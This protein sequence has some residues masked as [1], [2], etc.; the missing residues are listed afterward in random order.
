[1]SEKKVILV[2]TTT[3]NEL[4]LK[5][6]SQSQPQDAI[7]CLNIENH[8]LSAYVDCNIGPSISGRAYHDLD[9]EWKIPPLK[10]KP[11][12][13]LMKEVETLCQTILEDSRVDW[14]GSNWRGY[15]GCDADHVKDQIQNI[16]DNNDFDCSKIWGSWDACDWI[17]ECIQYFRNE[18]IINNEHKITA[19]TTNK[20]IE[21]LAEKLEEEAKN[22]HDVTIE[23]T[24]DYLI[25]LRDNLRDDFYIDINCNHENYTDYKC[26][27]CNYDFCQDCMIS[28]YYCPVC[29]ADCSEFYGGKK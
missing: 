21:N 25:S 11:L 15:L 14:D 27:S 23:G 10:I 1:M 9:I 12:E 20:E 4:F 6:S 28:L 19:K 26:K 3:D 29:G 7:L 16:I 5:Y 18:C 22:E 17:S 2:P 13:N 24:E 8:E